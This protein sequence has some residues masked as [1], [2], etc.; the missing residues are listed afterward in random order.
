MDHKPLDPLGCLL[1]FVQ[2]V[3][4]DPSTFEA[5]IRLDATTVD[6]AKGYVLDKIIR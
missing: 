6:G 1:S 3:Q 5:L 4:V 2:P